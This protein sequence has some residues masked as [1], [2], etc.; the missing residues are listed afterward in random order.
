MVD[1]DTQNL[2]VLAI[3]AGSL[4]AVIVVAKLVALEHS[5]GRQ[6]E[7]GTWRRLGHVT[8]PVCSASFNPG[9]IKK[10]WRTFTC[11]NCEEVLTYETRSFD[12]LLLAF[13]IYGTPIAL[14][15]CG[16][17]GLTLAAASVGGAIVFL[18]LGIFIYNLFSPP[19]AAQREGFG[20][21]RLTDKPKRQ[22]IPPEGK[23]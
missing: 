3:F 22:E 11:P 20:G 23:S 1:A 15:F 18:F 2:L 14:Y 4:I 9:K 19:I 17:R 5:I 13:S 12:Y 7:D 10:A 16:F 21:L 8:C 6:T